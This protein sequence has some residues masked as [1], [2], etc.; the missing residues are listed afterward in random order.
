M[1]L[2]KSALRGALL[3]LAVGTLIALSW[4]Y[5]HAGSL[6]L[7]WT[8]PPVSAT[9]GPAVGHKLYRSTAAAE[10]DN[11]TTALPLFQTIATMSSSY[12]DAA[13]PD[14]NGKVCYEITAYNEGGES[15]RS[16][17]AARATT[18]NP[19]KAPTLVIK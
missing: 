4:T 19:P 5:V 18:V 8:D 9:T 2:L 1:R 7:E 11:A 16:N 17:R 10:C 12:V 6:T 3:G 15:P 13:V 14:Q